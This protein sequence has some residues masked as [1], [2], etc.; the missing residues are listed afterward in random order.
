MSDD[1]IKYAIDRLIAAGDN[2]GARKLALQAGR[3][4]GGAANAVL[5]KA[6]EGKILSSRELNSLTVK[7]LGELRDAHPAIL[8]RSMDLIGNPSAV[9]EQARGELPQ[10]PPGAGADYVIPTAQLVAMS[11]EQ[12]QALK[13]SQPDLYRRSVEQLGRGPETSHRVVGA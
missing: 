13:A 12:Q 10:I 6:A 9:L 2:V 5:A 4:Q 11:P 1:P 3:G 7:E 8:E